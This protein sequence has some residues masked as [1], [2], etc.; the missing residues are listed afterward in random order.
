MMSVVHLIRN[1]FRSPFILGLLAVPLFLSACTSAEMQMPT[2][3]VYHNDVYRSAPGP[4]GKAPSEKE[5]KTVP[6]HGLKYL[7]SETMTMANPPAIGPDGQPIGGAS[8]YRGVADDLVARLLRNLG[9]PME[10]VFVNN[11]SAMA[12]ALRESLRQNGVPVAVNPGDGPFVLNSHIQGATA[13]ITFY[14]NHDPV[15]SEAG[16][17]PMDR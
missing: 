14:S 4:E 6:V 12:P 16:S 5:A 10:P 1:A 11:T 3:Y 9:R 2:G 17:Y 7:G 13:G 15:T 8:A